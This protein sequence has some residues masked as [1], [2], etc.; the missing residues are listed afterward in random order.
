MKKLESVFINDVV[1]GPCEITE[2]VLIELLQSPAM[3]RLQGINQL[4]IPP[5]YDP[6]TV[7]FQG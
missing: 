5:E 7:F 3:L 4:G 2:P 1:Y 6:T